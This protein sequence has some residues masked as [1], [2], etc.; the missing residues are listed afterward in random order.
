MKL[1]V[2]L[3]PNHPAVDVTQINESKLKENKI[4]YLFYPNRHPCPPFIQ[5]HSFSD[6]FLRVK[7]HIKGSSRQKAAAT[8]SAV[9]L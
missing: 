6:I 5:F 4:K 7:H 1:S 3:V 8:D 2:T 9:K